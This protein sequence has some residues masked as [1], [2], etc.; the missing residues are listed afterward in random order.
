MSCPPSFRYVDKVCSLI[1]LVLIKPT[2]CLFKVQILFLIIGRFGM[3]FLILIKW[4]SSSAKN[5]P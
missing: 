2:Y 1:V 3:F 4:P 5:D